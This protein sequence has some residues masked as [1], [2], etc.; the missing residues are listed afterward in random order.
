MGWQGCIIIWII[1]YS[2]VMHFLALIIW[3][4]NGK[5]SPLGNE[6][7]NELVDINFGCICI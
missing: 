1:N 4:L 7:L 5:P 6:K 2:F 3:T